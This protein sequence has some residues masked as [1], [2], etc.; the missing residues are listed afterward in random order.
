VEKFRHWAGQADQI[1][2]A[3]GGRPDNAIRFFHWLESRR[4]GWFVNN[5]TRSQGKAGH[6]KRE[7]TSFQLYG[8]LIMLNL[9]RITFDQAL[10][11]AAWRIEEIETGLVPA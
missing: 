3:V 1:I 2:A 8:G 11:Y 7:W 5:K 4:T 10:A 6:S 9:D